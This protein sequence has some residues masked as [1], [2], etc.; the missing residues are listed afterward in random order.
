ML[1]GIEHFEVIEGH[2][3]LEAVSLSSECHPDVVVLDLAMPVMDGLTAARKISKSLPQTPILMCT[4]HASAQ[5]EL[6]AQKAGVRKIISKA[7]THAIIPAIRELLPA[8][9]SASTPSETPSLPT[10]P[11]ATIPESSATPTP[12]L[13][14]GNGPKSAA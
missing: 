6:E 13:A 11:L 5:L 10:P 2:D 12:P 7:D 3:G 8:T 9:P 14:P 1:E 4:M